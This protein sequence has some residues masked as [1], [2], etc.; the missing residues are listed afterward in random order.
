[1]GVTRRGVQ[2]IPRRFET[3]PI[4][5]Y[6]LCM[7]DQAPASK[8]KSDGHKHV[9]DTGMEVCCFFLHS[10]VP[11]IMYTKITMG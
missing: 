9:G 6:K 11:H 8:R 4:L 5:A 1:M 7:A 2:T 10:E 3:S